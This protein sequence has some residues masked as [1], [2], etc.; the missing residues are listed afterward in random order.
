METHT[1]RL[2]SLNGSVTGVKLRENTVVQY[3][4]IPYAEINERFDLPAA[5][6]NLNGTTFDGT[7]HG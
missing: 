6:H 4:G 5:V 3:R 2:D 7:K 1:R